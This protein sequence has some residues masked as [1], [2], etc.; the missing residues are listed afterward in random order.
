MLQRD[1]CLL[2][3]N[4]RKSWLEVQKSDPDLIKVREYLSEGLSPSHKKTPRDILR[5]MNC[6]SL[7]SNPNDGL[8]IV[9]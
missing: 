6:V 5:Y 8:V 3:Y 7:S 2:T 9:N 4:S 1:S